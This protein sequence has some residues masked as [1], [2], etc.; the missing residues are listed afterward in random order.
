MWHADNSLNTSALS[1]SE[2]SQVPS[3]NPSPIVSS[4]SSHADDGYSS[5]QVLS[6]RLTSTPV[7][8][9]S[10]S[11]QNSSQNRHNMTPCCRPQIENPLVRVGLVPQDLTN[12]FLS[13]QT[14]ERDKRPSRRITGVL[15]LTS[16]E[17]VEM[18]RE[19]D[20]KEA[21]EMKQR[22]K[23]ERESARRWRRKKSERGRKWSVGR[24]RRV[25]G[26]KRVSVPSS[27]FQVKTNKRSTSTN[28]RAA[29]HVQYVLQRDNYRESTSES[30]GGDTVCFLCNS[31]EPLIA[32]S[33]VFWVDCDHWGEWAHTHC[34]LGSNTA[35]RQFV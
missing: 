7:A 5:P 13:L 8:S 32:S 31:R 2:E 6:G 9:G 35:T 26:R 22:R 28:Q 1:S 18:M 20:R 23:E 29:V 21:S 12:I 27:I 14:Y 15:V 25:E 34:A 11:S 30:E 4:L 17:Y 16:N 3:V 19:K 33:R 24:R 10:A